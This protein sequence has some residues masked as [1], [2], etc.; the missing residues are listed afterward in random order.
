M[1]GMLSSSVRMDAG[2]SANLASTMPAPSRNNV[3]LRASDNSIV[4]DGG[5][6]FHGRVSIGI[7]EG[8][9]VL[10]ILGYLWTRNAQGG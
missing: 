5:A 7:L 6:D 4:G 3:G 8:L 9:V 1:D 2:A 10:L